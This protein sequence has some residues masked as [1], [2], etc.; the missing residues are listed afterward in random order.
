MKTKILFALIIIFSVFLKIEIS[1][2]ENLPLQIINIKPAGTGSPAIPASY[3]IFYA[4]PGIE[5][6]I[7]AA[8]IG[9]D[10]PY[11]FSLSNAPTGMTVDEAGYILWTNPQESANNIGLRVTDS[12]GDYVD[13]I[14]SISVQTSGFKFVDGGATIN[15]DGSINSPYSSIENMTLSASATDIVYF[16]SGTYLVPARGD[17]TINNASAFEWNNPSNTS[18]QWLA[19]PDE[20][21]TL[22][23]NNNRYLYGNSSNPF[24]FQGLRFYQGREYFFRTSSGLNYSTFL[25][26]I[27]DTLTL[28]RTDYNSNQGTYF[29]MHAG[30][31][32][33][34]IFQGNDFSNFTGTQGIGSLYDQNTTLV[35][36]NSFFDFS[37]ANSTN[38]VLA[39]KIGISGLTFRGN[40]VILSA[41]DDF[42]LLGGSTNSMFAD[43]TPYGHGPKS[44]NIEISYNYFRHYGSGLVEFN[45]YNDQGVTW[46]YR[47][48]F[49]SPLQMTNLNEDTGG[50]EGP[51]YINN[52]VLQNTSSG[53][54]YHYT[55]SG[56]YTTCV[57]QSGN[58]G[59]TSGIIEGDGNLTEAYSQYLG[60]AG[61]QFADGR[62]PLDLLAQN[63]DSPLSPTG[64]NIL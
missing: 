3:R 16:R 40:K 37:G 9:G 41:Q 23:L 47:N 43:G 20:G 27:F 22:D 13:T 35:E 8:V 25:D 24:Y 55:C 26:N 5:Y 28:E 42:G 10:Y 49:G 34:L 61:W 52:N 31:G 38:Q 11:T 64:L 12:D 56:N 54:N 2:A 44:E 58:I 46:I 1:R 32:H 57:S 17:H 59:A 19:Y 14:W 62:T 50:C 15:G 29:T 53:I 18:S 60:L 51:W 7:R 30:T 48:T 6:K 39:F 36:N 33:Y 21:V 45:R 4:Y 63:E